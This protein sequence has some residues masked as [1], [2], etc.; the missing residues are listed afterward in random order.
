M[1]GF[2]NGTALGA[3][4]T[5]MTLTITADGGATP[6]FTQTFTTLASAET[7]FTDNAMDLG[8]LGTG[9]LAG[10]TLTLTATLS[11][12]TASHGDGFYASLIVGDPP[13]A[14]A[15]H[16]FID[17]MAGLGGSGGS[18]SASRLRTADEPAPAGGR[19]I[20]DGIRNAQLSGELG[21]PTEPGE[22]ERVSCRILSTDSSAN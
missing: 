6:L 10:S 5:S 15:S 9:A 3:G 4:F 2:Y 21:R 18:M 1:V 22:G 11:I 16:R 20:A 13:G 12:T 17:A 14:S 7:F 19:K 8:K